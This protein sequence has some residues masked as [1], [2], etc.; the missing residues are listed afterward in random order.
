MTCEHGFIGACVE[1]D[2]CGQS[3]EADC[4]RCGEPQTEGRCYPCAAHFIAFA[5][6]HPEDDELQERGLAA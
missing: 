6:G 5:L 4:P 2:G 1:C 3:P